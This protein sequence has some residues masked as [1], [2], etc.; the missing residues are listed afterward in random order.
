[1]RNTMVL[2]TIALMATSLA[3]EAR[4]ALSEIIKGLED[5]GYEITDVDVDHNEIEIEARNA[6]GQKVDIDVDP[7]TGAIRRE[8]LDD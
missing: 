5:K 8:R 6:S 1:M 4:V 7:A 2:A 3:A